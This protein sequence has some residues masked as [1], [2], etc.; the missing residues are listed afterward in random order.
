LVLAL[1][2]AR[3]SSIRALR[4]CSAALPGLTLTA[5]RAF[6]AVYSCAQYA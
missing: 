3:A 1:T 5:K 2:F 4:A 6:E